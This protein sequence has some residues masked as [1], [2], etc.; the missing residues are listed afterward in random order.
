MAQQAKAFAV[1]SIAS[2]NVCFFLKWF[3]HAFNPV[4]LSFPNAVTL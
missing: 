3:S 1:Q 4:A 2:K